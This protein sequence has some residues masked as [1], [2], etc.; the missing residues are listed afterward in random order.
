MTTGFTGGHEFFR[1]IL[2]SS[3][4]HFEYLMYPLYKLYYKETYTGEILE[5]IIA[6]LKWA[7]ERPNIDLTKVLPN[8]PHTNKQI[9]QYIE[10]LLKALS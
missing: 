10:I 7:D 5:G 2:M 3:G 4:Q 1:G 8:L 9:H 6:A